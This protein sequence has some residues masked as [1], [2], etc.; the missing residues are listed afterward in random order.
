MFTNR[1]VR[2]FGT[3]RAR[4]SFLKR[5]GAP[6]S[7]PSF[8][9]LLFALY[10]DVVFFIFSKSECKCFPRASACLGRAMHPLSC[11]RDAMLVSHTLFLS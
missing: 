11:I 8:E 6:N 7:L 10:L 5:T 3:I 2:S 4:L 9:L 1:R